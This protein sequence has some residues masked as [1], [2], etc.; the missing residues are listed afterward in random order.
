M[1]GIG[2]GLGGYCAVA[3]GSNNGAQ[4]YGVGAQFQDPSRFIPVKSAKG[5]Y[6]PHIVQ[7]GPYI[8]NG[9]LVDMGSANVAIY[10]DATVQV[11]GDF[12]NKGM[13]LLFAQM[14][15][16]YGSQT[17]PQSVLV[18]GS[19]PA[20][21]LNQGAQPYQAL[22]Y[23]DGSW[24]DMEVLVKRTDGTAEYQDYHSC[25][26][27]KGEFVFP[28]DNIVTYGYDVDAA[29]VTLATGAQ[30]SGTD[31]LQA[32]VPLTMPNSSSLFQV[33]TGG[34]L[35]GIDG[36]R[37][38]TVTVTPKL[39]TDRIY[40]GNAYKDE[41]ITNGLIEVGIA[42]EMDYTVTAQSDIFASFIGTG[43]TGPQHSPI[44]AQFTPG[45][46]TTGGLLIQAVGAEIGSS[47][48]NDTVG[49]LFPQV[50]LM[51][52]GEAPLEGVDI[53]KNTVMLKA[54][55]D[56]YGDAAAYGFLYTADTGV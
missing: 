46:L 25:K 6:N 37:K 26:I 43:G 22:G 35:T 16:G 13:A 9:A 40:I 3:N 56:A 47:G 5:T 53:I 45:G 29:Y 8:R 51:S 15:G 18:E 11:V 24:F 12:M 27:V 4:Y 28:R 55:L 38:A 54:T 49:F 14:L 52:G 36:C 34:G 7:G 19:A 2:S 42:L 33:D 32:A 31:P 44:G 48:I 20:Y 50:F 39:A 1:S 41:P 10:L 17:Y 21:Q 23:Q 30:A